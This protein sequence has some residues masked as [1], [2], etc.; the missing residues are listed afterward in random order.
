M[1]GLPPTQRQVLALAF[2]R[3]LSHQEIAQSLGLPLGTV[4]SHIR[5]AQLS[6]RVA[7]AGEPS[8]P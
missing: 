2:F 8:I 5:R 1:G 7:L 3:H 4:K 6:L